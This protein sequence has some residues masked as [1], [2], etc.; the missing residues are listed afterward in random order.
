[1]CVPRHPVVSGIQPAGDVDHHRA[2]VRPKPRFCQPVQHDGA[3]NDAAV[4]GCVLVGKGKIVVQFLDDFFRFCIVNRAAPPALLRPG[5][6]GLQHGLRHAGESDFFFHV[7]LPP[8]AKS[9]IFPHTSRISPDAPSPAPRVPFSEC[10]EC[11]PAGNS[12]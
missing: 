12:A 5:I 7:M 10:R 8:F 9:E 1:M 11:V 4:H 3:G 6:N 2:G